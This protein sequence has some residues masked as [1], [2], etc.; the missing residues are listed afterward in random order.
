MA[1]A[2]VIYHANCMDGFGAA[3]AFHKLREDTY[4]EGCVT[5]Q[6]VN[7][8]EPP[9][10]N[11]LEKHDHCY[12]LDFSY[13]RSILLQISY[14]FEKTLVLDHHKTAREDLENW[15]TKPNNLFITFD[16]E[17]SGA[18]LTWRTFSSKEPPPLIQ[19]IEDR[20]LWRF[21]LFRSKETNA[22]IA[23]ETKDFAVYD[24]LDLVLTHT[25]ELA[26]SIGEAL[27]NY[28]QRISEQIAETARPMSIQLLNGENHVGL[29][30]N[31]PGAFASEV[32]NILAK[33][34][35][36]FGCTHY[37][38]KDGSV[39]FSLRSEGDY[40][41]SRIALAYG[42]GG[43]KNASGFVLPPGEETGNRETMH[44]WQVN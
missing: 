15:P 14:L 25:P 13:P 11:L 9:P 3:W 43:H 16:M 19:Y 35:R 21:K 10:W 33:R 44:I 40:D 23:N 8:G 41:V 1:E 24:K 29:V 20:D 26:Q 32:G 34:S 12:I 27:M 30:C 5:Y 7:Y 31:A 22:Y 17:Q 2:L 28:H 38:D 36:T 42:G 39:K 4:E 18:G 37:V 6:A